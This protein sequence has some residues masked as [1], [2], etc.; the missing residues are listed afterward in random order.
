MRPK[1]NAQ[2]QR[3]GARRVCNR[4]PRFDRGFFR[5]VF[6]QRDEQIEHDQF[7][8]GQ[9]VGVFFEICDH[10]VVLFKYERKRAT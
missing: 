1:A 5:A 6:D 10:V 8:G 7:V 4:F 2:T 3:T 9:R